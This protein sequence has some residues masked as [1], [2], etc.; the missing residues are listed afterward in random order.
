VLNQLKGERAKNDKENIAATNTSHTST[1]KK[2]YTLHIPSFS[3]EKYLLIL[4]KYDF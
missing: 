1:L 2:N 4:E 3:A